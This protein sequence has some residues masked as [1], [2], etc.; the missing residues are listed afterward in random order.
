M[1][2]CISPPKKRRCIDNDFLS[3]SSAN[4]WQDAILKSGFLFK[5][6]KRNPKFNRYWFV[7]KDHVLSYYRDSSNLHFPR[8]NLDLR[9][10]ISAQVTPGSQQGESMAFTI[11]NSDRAHHFKAESPASAKEWV[12]QTQK[13]IFRSHNEGD[14][15]KICL[16]IENILDLEEN[17][18]LDF[19]DTFRIRIIDNDETYA[20]DEVSLGIRCV[21]DSPLGSNSMLQYFF[22][23]FSHG[24]DALSILRGL[25]GSNNLNTSSIGTPS[26]AATR[27]PGKTHHTEAEKVDE[28]NVSRRAI[29]SAK[30]ASTRNDRDS[31][32][33]QQMTVDHTSDQPVKSSMLSDPPM[34]GHVGED[35]SALRDSSD[36][37]RSSDDSQ[38]SGSNEA[39]LESNPI[40]A[41]QFLSGSDVFRQSTLHALDPRQAPSHSST[42]PEKS[43]GISNEKSHPD[44]QS[45]SRSRAVSPSCPLP[46]S[47]SA[48]SHINASKITI[49][50]SSSS[51]SLRDLMRA[52]VQPLNKATGLAGLLWARSQQVRTYVSSESKGYYE[53]VSGMWAGKRVHFDDIEGVGSTDHIRDLEEDEARQTKRFHTHFALSDSE[54]LVATY[55]GYLSRLVPVFGKFYLGATKLCFR[56]L[57]PGTRTNVSFDRQ[58]HSGIHSF[59]ADTV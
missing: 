52:G 10:G 14:T 56:S 2:L 46:S 41:S 26:Q 19:A 25:I 47:E 43:G 21:C 54:K 16:P 32:G 33:Q 40:R 12:K 8:G 13:A 9:S 11:T 59:L 37:S 7:L 6:G 5:R 29:E 15:V 35:A 4:R 3:G 18:V 36:S 53:K 24:K 49:Q 57:L 17:P 28:E 39:E 58:F 23:F 50:P 38:L 22:S 27:S 45:T 30:A 42:L 48:A 1:L 31:S 34:P 44:A 20:I 51:T 55:H